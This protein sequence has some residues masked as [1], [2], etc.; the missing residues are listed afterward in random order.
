MSQYTK[1][2]GKTGFNTPAIIAAFI[3]AKAGKGW[4]EAD[5]V[6]AVESAYGPD[7]SQKTGVDKVTFGREQDKLKAGTVEQT[8][9]TA[10]RVQRKR[11]VVTSFAAWANGIERDAVKFEKR[12]VQLTVIGWGDDSGARELWVMGFAAKAAAKP[13]TVRPTVKAPESAVQAP[14]AA[15]PAIVAS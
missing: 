6:S 2:N 15:I 4:R 11:D 9:T 10:Q 1:T 5:L 8:V 14:I 13:A 7:N 3:T 12:G